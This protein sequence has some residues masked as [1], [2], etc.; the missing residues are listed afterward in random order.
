MLA[1]ITRRTF[2]VGVTAMVAVLVTGCGDGQDALVPAPVATPSTRPSDPAFSPDG[3]LLAFVVSVGRAASLHVVPV[4]GGESK[5]VLDS[6]GDVWQPVF[7]ADSTRI[8][9]QRQGRRP[10]DAELWSVRV[11]GGGD[12]QILAEVPGGDL[13]FSAD[14]KRVAFTYE[15]DGA[16]GREIYVMNL[17]G[18]GRRKVARGSGDLALP[19]FSPDGKRVAFVA[20]PALRAAREIFIVKIDGTGARQVTTNGSSPYRLAFAADGRLFYTA[21]IGNK[22]GGGDTWL[23][24]ADGSAPQ[25]VIGVEV[26]QTVLSPDGRTVAFFDDDDQADGELWT[27]NVDGS[28]RRRL[29]PASAL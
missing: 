19:A 9:Y 1:V 12:K 28:N 14:R 2:G 21:T 6:T 22:G 13:A 25:R 29:V 20:E 18:T 24:N 8:F 26:N 11:D 7:S 15:A 27:M 4:G 3:R 10:V 17:D 23:V 5:R 16:D